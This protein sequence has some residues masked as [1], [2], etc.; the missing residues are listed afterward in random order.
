M[1]LN[2]YLRRR[3]TEHNRLAVTAFGGGPG[4]SD[5]DDW[6][7]RDGQWRR[8]RPGPGPQTRPAEQ[9]DLYNTAHSHRYNFDDHVRT[10]GR[11]E[12]EVNQLRNHEHEGGNQLG[13]EDPNGYFNNSDKINTSATASSQ[14]LWNSPRYSNI[15]IEKLGMNYSTQYTGSGGINLIKPNFYTPLTREKFNGNDDEYLDYKLKEL[16]LM[17]IYSEGLFRGIYA[18]ANRLNNQMIAAIDFT[19][20]NSQNSITRSDALLR[21][22]LGKHER[23]PHPD[24]KQLNQPATSVNRILII[25]VFLLL[26]LLLN[27]LK[28]L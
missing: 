15:P 8:I 9:Q 5:A 14:S 16:E 19:S 3:G 20:A 6:V 23:S 12:N 18:E 28:I 4:G 10:L 17:L 2:N 25:A 21:A 24:Q 26:A 1:V 7:L 11:V 13:L 22:A 27:N